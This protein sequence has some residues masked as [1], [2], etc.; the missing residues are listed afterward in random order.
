MYESKTGENEIERK[1]MLYEEDE[2]YFKENMK[3][4]CYKVPRKGRKRKLAQ[5]KK[6]GRY[7]DIKKKNRIV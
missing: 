2:K 7:L 6:V 4:K 5:R 1:G 3:K